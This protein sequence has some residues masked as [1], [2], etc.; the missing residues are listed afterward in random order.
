MVDIGEAVGVIAAQ[1]IGEP[2][3]QLTLRTFH[4]GGAAARIV[5]RVRRS[6]AKHRGHV[7]FENVDFSPARAKARTARDP[8]ATARSSCSTTRPAGCAPLQAALRRGR[9]RER[10]RARR[11]RRDRSSSGIRIPTPILAERDG[12]VHFVDIKEGVTFRDEV[13][14]DT[15][16]EHSR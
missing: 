10:G 3:T 2:G 4:I 13:D 1:S 7:V 8:A 9:L 11:R 16:H 14:E 6:R 12:I 15:G 5:E